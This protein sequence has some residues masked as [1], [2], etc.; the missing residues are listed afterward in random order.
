MTL[1]LDLLWDNFLTSGIKLVP[2]ETLKR[3]KVLN[4]FELV[5]SIAALSLALFYL[6]ISAFFLFY[7]SVIAGLLGIGVVLLLRTTKNLVLTGNLAVFILWLLL[8]GIRWNTGGISVSGPL[9]LIWIWNAVLI[10]LAIFL[11]GYMW[12]TI[13]TCLVFVES[14]IAISLFRAGY[15]FDNL[16]P[17]DI[18]STYALGFYLAFQVEF[19]THL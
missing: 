8:I 14:G 9:L 13:W 18:S 3:I 6:F 15:N 7:I 19:M 5:F 4:L 1:N 2:A 17:P 10:L 16:I 11:T 12:G